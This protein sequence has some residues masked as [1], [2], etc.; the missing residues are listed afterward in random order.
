MSFLSK[1]EIEKSKEWILRTWDRLERKMD[2]DDRMTDFE[3]ELKGLINKYSKENG[4]NTSDWILAEFL[5][6][7]LDSF[8]YAVNKR[9]RWYGVALYPGWSTVPEGTPEVTT[10]HKILKEK[11]DE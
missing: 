2:K 11:E 3:R 7:V 9:D 5:S 8:D 6:Q 10:P 4:S 1:E